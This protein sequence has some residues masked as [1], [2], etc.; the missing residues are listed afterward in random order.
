MA[1][2]RELRSAFDELVGR[3]AESGYVPDAVFREGDGSGIETICEFLGRCV[4]C[5]D[6]LGASSRMAIEDAYKRRFGRAP[7]ADRFATYARAARRIAEL[8]RG[9]SLSGGTYRG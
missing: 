9:V 4:G 5:E 8:R 1:L 6:R 7:A 3:I 2:S